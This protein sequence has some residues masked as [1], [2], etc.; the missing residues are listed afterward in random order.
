[1]IIIAIKTY[2]AL[3]HG[4]YVVYVYNCVIIIVFSSQLL[5]F[6]A[7]T[8]LYTAIYRPSK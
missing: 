5:Q 7:Y 8:I 6:Q 4:R 1:M 3:T 2:Y